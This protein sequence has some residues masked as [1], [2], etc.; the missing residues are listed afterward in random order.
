MSVVRIG[1]IVSVKLEHGLG[2][3]KDMSS[4]RVKALLE[5]LRQELDAAKVDPESLALMRELDADIR[6]VLDSDS[7]EG[8]ID[9]LMSR[10]KAMEVEFA[11]K[12]RVGEGILREL[13][14]TLAEIGV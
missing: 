5:Q 12:H 13:I 3:D 1:D 14:D 7:A 2:T 11:V 10:V 6:H 4:T 9:T 8:P